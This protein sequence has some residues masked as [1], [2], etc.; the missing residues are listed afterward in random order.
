MQCYVRINSTGNEPRLYEIEVVPTEVLKKRPHIYYIC[1][2][3]F[4]VAFEMPRT[5]WTCSQRQA[6]NFPFEVNFTC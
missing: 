6:L 4:G 1:G 3:F 5:V 2:L